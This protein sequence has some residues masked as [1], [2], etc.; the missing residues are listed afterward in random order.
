MAIGNPL[1]ALHYPADS[2][3]RVYELIDDEFVP[4][5]NNSGFTGTGFNPN[6]MWHKSSGKLIYISKNATSAV[7]MAAS[8]TGASPTVIGS[9]SIAA[10][11][12]S[13][14][15]NSTSFNTNSFMFLPIENGSGA[16]PYNVGIN[17][18]ATS[19]RQSAVL[20]SVTN[21][22][23]FSDI[24]TSI[25]GNFAAITTNNNSNL[26]YMI[27]PSTPNTSTAYPYDKAFVNFPVSVGMNTSK[28]FFSYDGSLLVVAD[29][30][31]ENVDVYKI[32]VTYS[33]PNIASNITLTKTNTITPQLGVL[34]NVVSSPDKTTMAFV[35]LKDTIYT[36]Y[37]FGKYGDYIMP[38]EKTFTNFGNNISF[39]GDGN[40]IVDGTT[41]KMLSFNGTTWVQTDSAM[42]NIV[43]GAATQTLSDHV[44]NNITMSRFYD[45]ALGTLTGGGPTDLRLYLL[46]GNATFVKNQ[47][48]IS[49]LSGSIISNGMWPPSGVK[50]DISRSEDSTRYYINSDTI[51]QPVVETSITARYAVIYDF[52]TS[53]PM[54]FYDLSTNRVFPTGSRINISFTENHLVTYT[55]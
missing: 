25:D 1:L 42:S 51:S 5:G 19:I 33:S 43:V 55:E 24:A 3:V 23:N 21:R 26:I 32:N 41:R 35:Y 10:F 39:T 46:D 34:Q 16:Y 52:L 2:V 49:E 8:V 47:T 54:I 14:V 53:K 15:K 13:T 12:S 50:V 6:M 4:V 20:L 28:S 11:S 27:G 37:L 18:T 30:S 31:G 29:I 44:Q 17:N 36:T 7:F 45:G 40:K 38:L 48:N 22:T 9:V